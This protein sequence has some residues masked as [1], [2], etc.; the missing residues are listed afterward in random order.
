MLAMN[1]STTENDRA[2]ER[3][4]AG[5]HVHDGAAGKVEH[6]PLVQEAVRVPRPVR[7]RGIDED[8]EQAHEE[9]IARESHPL[10][11]R[12]GDQR[13]RNDRELQLEQREED[14][15]NRGRQ[16]RVRIG[17]DM[18]EEEEGA[19]ITDDA[20]NAVPKRETEPHRHPEQTDD[21][22]R[23]KT[24]QHRGDDVLGLHHAAVEEGEP[25]CH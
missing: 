17:A 11:E 22:H 19:R 18:L 1:A 16:C 10:G 23:H 9:H 3:R 6:A 2:G 21:R 8:R 14:E 20:A 12:A 4:K 25:R 13:R 24:L 7:E 5:R 15:R